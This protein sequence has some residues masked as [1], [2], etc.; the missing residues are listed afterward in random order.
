MYNLRR[1]A[2]IYGVLCNFVFCSATLHAAF[3]KWLED[4]SVEFG[5]L[6]LLSITLDVRKTAVKSL[7]DVHTQ[8]QKQRNMS[9]MRYLFE[10]AAPLLLFTS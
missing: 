9:V 1:C 3:R 6:V 4:V 8:T 10:H 7:C 5:V 2:Q